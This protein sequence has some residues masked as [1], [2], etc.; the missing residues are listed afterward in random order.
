MKKTNAMRLLDKAGIAYAVQQYEYDESD[1]SGVAAA[2][3]LGMDAATVF[4][5]LVA[6]GD[7]SGYV[8]AMLPVAQELE[9]KGFARASGNKRM[10]MLPLKDL[11]SVTGYMRGG[12]SPLGMKKAFPTYIEES[13][14]RLDAIGISAGQRGVQ[15]VLPPTDLINYLNITLFSNIS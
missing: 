6:R 5:T 8:V 10:E 7:K 3:K 12:C 11:L 15:I 14:L 13:A 2:A 4:K 9:L 1:L